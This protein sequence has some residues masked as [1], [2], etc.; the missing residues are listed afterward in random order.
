[1][2]ELKNP[3][4]ETA[5]LTAAFNQLQTY[6]AQIPS[7]FRTNAALVTTDGL[8]ARVGSLTADRSASCRGARPTARVAPKGVPGDV[9]C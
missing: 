3:G 2:I 4:G 5:T 1:V 6:K 8:Q 7:L 9:R